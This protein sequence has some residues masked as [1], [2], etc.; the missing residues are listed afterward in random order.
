MADLLSFAFCEAQWYSIYDDLL[1]I[2]NEWIF[3]Q[4]GTEQ[5]FVHYVTGHNASPFKL[6]ANVKTRPTGY[7]I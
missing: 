6:I 4:N 1:L 3:V 5:K 7:Q 2:S